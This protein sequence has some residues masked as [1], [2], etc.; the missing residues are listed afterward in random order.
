MARPL[1]SMPFRALISTQAQVLSEQLPLAMLIGAGWMILQS[2][3]HV[4][5]NL[6]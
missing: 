2:T 4:V 6:L 5:P 3:S 1:S